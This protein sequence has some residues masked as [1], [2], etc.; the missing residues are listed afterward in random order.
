[1]NQRRVLVDGESLFQIIDGATVVLP[2]ERNTPQTE[3]RGNRTR[4]LRENLH[5]QRFRVGR[6]SLIQVCVAKPDERGDGIRLELKRAL[7]PD[8]GVCRFAPKSIQVRQKIRPPDF[9][10]IERLSVQQIR[11]GRLTVLGSQQQRPSLP[12]R[13]SE[14][15]IRNSSV[16]NRRVER[17]V[18][19]TKLFLGGWSCA[20]DVG[21]GD[22]P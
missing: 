7:E 8:N 20:R 10:G 5:Q 21:E 6:P 11:L 22:G 4:L 17:D 15:D 2:G 18:R 12:V 16:L 1:M 14:N 13:F 3:Q 19:L 9:H